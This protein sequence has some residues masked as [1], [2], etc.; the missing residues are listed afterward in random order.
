MFVLKF[1]IVIQQFIF[2][3]ISNLVHMHAADFGKGDVWLT[4]YRDRNKCI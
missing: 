4:V 3:N 1:W 2:F